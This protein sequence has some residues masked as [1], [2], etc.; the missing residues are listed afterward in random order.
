MYNAPGSCWLVY[1]LQMP[2]IQMQA[3]VGRSVRLS[4]RLVLA[5][6]KGAVLKI[7]L[8]WPWLIFT[9]QQLSFSEIIGAQSTA[10]PE[11]FGDYGQALQ[12]ICGLQWLCGTDSAVANNMWTHQPPACFQRMQEWESRLKAEHRVC[13]SASGHIFLTHWIWLRVQ[14][15]S[16]LSGWFKCN[17]LLSKGA[18]DAWTGQCVKLQGF[19]FH[20][21]IWQNME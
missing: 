16:S 7:K 6:R 18:D 14:W 1:L 17:V 9:L 21:L 15:V 3:S 8:H 13:T 2:E 19:L 5:K 20:L 4:W 10:Q 12:G 11:V